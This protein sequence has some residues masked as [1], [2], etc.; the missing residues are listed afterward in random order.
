MQRTSQGSSAYKTAYVAHGLPAYLKLSSKGNSLSAYY[1]NDG[2]SYALVSGST[3]TLSLA[4]N[5]LA[6]MVVTSLDAPALGA[7]TLTDVTL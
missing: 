1:S 3:Q 5:L 6:A 7:V 2:L 4:S